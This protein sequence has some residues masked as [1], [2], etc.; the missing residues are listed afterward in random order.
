M[1]LN[2]VY[3]K[4]ADVLY[5][6]GRKCEGKALLLGNKQPIF[7]AAAPWTPEAA[8]GLGAF[9]GTLNLDPKNPEVADAVK[10]GYMSVVGGKPDKQADQVYAG[11]YKTWDGPCFN[12]D[13]LKF[14]EPL[15]RDDSSMPEQKD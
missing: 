10:R 5:K 9:Y 6:A 8:P 12:Q 7:R 3:A 2:K 14:E 11:A 13:N 15:A 1:L 4:L